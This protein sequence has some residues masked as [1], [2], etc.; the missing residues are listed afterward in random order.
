MSDVKNTPEDSVRLNEA[1]LDAAVGGATTI[2][3][4]PC[5]KSPRTLIPCIKT[6][7]TVSTTQT[8]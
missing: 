2:S 5:I 8:P 1:E 4:I 7:K 6:I 3:L